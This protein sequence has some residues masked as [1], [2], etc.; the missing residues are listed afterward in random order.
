M[1]RFINGN[2]L[3]SLLLIRSDFKK[4]WL[5][6]ILEIKQPLIYFQIIKHWA[7]SMIYVLIY[8]NIQL[9]KYVASWS[10]GILALSQDNNIKTCK[11]VIHQYHL[12]LELFLR[13]FLYSLNMSSSSSGGATN[14]K[15]VT[16]KVELEIV[17]GFYCFQTGMINDNDILNDG[18]WQSFTNAQ[19]FFGTQEAIAH[20]HIVDN[21]NSIYSTF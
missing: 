18:R 2:D 20:I 4:Q 21:D 19:P 3:A 8:T 14:S 7:C 15:K 1:I 10:Y 5:G 13:L 6:I 9:D 11:N 12:Y 17:L 16:C